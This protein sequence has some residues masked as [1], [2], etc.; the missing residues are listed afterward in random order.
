MWLQ[1]LVCVV[2]VEPDSQQARNGIQ[3]KCKEENKS[4][5]FVM[6]MKEI[7]EP[8]WIEA[9]WREIQMQY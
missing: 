9:F 6:Q 2:E 4:M 1:N 7:Q 5:L 3:L 8:L